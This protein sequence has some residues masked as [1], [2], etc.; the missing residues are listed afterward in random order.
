MNFVNR[1][2]LKSPKHFLSKK[3]EGLLSTRIDAFEKA[4]GC[5]LVFH[6]RKNLGEKP[7]HR[8][9]ELFFRFGLDKTSHHAAIL[10]VL[11]FNDRKYAVW[12]DSHVKKHSDDKLWTEVGDVIR[13]HMTK[14]ERLNALTSAMDLAQKSLKIE[15]PKSSG[16]FKQSLSNKPI[17]EE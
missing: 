6:F 14:G 8:A 1:L 16:D 17:T 10:V 2:R 5:E 15:N 9:E 3:E 12:V 7:L 13:N 11:S 4:T